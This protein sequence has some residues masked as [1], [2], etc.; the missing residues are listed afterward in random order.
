[1]PCAFSLR[2]LKQKHNRKETNFY[3]P[4]FY[5]YCFAFRHQMSQEIKN[6]AGNLS[7]LSSFQD[8]KKS[9]EA[10]MKQKVNF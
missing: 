2:A 9:A 1:M 5:D 6:F 7:A 3:E 10:D 4:V 8:T